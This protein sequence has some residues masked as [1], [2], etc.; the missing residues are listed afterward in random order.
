MIDCPLP[1]IPWCKHYRNNTHAIEDFLELIVRWEHCVRKQGINLI[2]FEPRPILEGKDP[3][4]NIITRE[5]IKI[6]VNE[7]NPN[8]SNIQKEVPIDA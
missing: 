8:Q 6:G 4:I 7:D 1:R 3:N 2:K 5:G